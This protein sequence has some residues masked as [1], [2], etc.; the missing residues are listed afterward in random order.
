MQ[1]TTRIISQ[2]ALYLIRSREIT[3]SLDALNTI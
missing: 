2:R 1:I 3:N